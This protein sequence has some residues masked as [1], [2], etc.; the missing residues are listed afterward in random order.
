MKRSVLARRRV[1]K[2]VMEP[3]RVV[4]APHVSEKTTDLVQNHNTYVFKV[5]REATKTDIRE[6]V[7]RIWNVQVKS[8]RIVNV[9]GKKRRIGRMVGFT[10]SWKKAIVRLAEGDGIDV[11]R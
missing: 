10:P 3:F 11:L 8:I 9:K 2:A 6:A 5:A 1:P 4:S 7:A